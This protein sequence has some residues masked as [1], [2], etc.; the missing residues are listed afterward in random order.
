MR[1]EGTHAQTC[2]VCQTATEVIESHHVHPIQ[3]G[4][5]QDGP[6]VW[7]CPGCHRLIHFQAENLTGKQPKKL[8]AGLALLKRAKPLIAAVVRAKI[9][10]L[11][12]RQEL[13]LNP[14][15]PRRL[16]LM[17]DEVTLYRLHLMK[18]D[19]GATNLTTYLQGLLTRAAAQHARNPLKDG[20]SR[21]HN[22]A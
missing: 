8:L 2:V 19:A 11:K 1:E 3:Y 18:V 14:K 12:R 15:Q 13:G 10:W 4:G 17:V 21:A 5:A 6:Q 22:K 9:G 20:V 16:M 7:L